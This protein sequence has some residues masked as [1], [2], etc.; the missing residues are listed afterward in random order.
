MNSV[1]AACFMVCAVLD[2]DVVGIIGWHTCVC[3]DGIDKF[4]TPVDPCDCSTSA[5]LT[6]ARQ[7]EV[8]WVIIGR[9]GSGT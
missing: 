6:A 2:A 8:A 5:P 9:V 1:I 4:E 3:Y 7:E